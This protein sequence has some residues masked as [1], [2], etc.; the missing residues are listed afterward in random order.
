MR[1][2]ATMTLYRIVWTDPPT[3]TDMMSNEALG[4]PLRDDTPEL[5]RLWR[6]I[7]AFDTLGRA[8]RHA[9]RNPWKGNA[10]IA[11]IQFGF[12]TLRAGHYTLWGDPHAILDCVIHVEHV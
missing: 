3:V 12:G 6:G 9:K 1:P 8:R 5:R 4:R 10:F 7:S 11:T 2:R